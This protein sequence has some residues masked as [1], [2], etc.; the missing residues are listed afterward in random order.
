[1][2]HAGALVTQ[3]QM[4]VVA[5]TPAIE[6]DPAIGR[7]MADGIAHEVFQRLG[8]AVQMGLH[9]AFDAERAGQPCTVPAALEAGVLA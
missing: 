4:P 1:M 2:R 8:Q 3:A 7:R 9:H 5:L 6:A